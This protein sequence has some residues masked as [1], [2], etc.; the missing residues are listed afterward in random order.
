MSDLRSS[1]DNTKYLGSLVFQRTHLTKSLEELATIIE[2][3]EEDLRT[4]NTDHSPSQTLSSSFPP[5]SPEWSPTGNSWGA[6]PLL[7]SYS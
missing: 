1:S 2:V 4:N 7:C 3:L 5:V 6:D